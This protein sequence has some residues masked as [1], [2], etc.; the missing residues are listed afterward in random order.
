MTPHT[1]PALPSQRLTRILGSLAPNPSTSAPQ[2]AMMR[3][4]APAAE[5]D[6]PRT[7][8]DALWILTRATAIAVLMLTALAPVS[9]QTRVQMIVASSSAA[10]LTPGDVVDGAQ[11]LSLGAAERVTL[12]D[13][14]GALRAIDGPFRGRPSDRRPSVEGG[15]GG[16]LAILADVLRL[17][18]DPNT[19]KLPGPWLA[20][21]QRTGHVCAQA[22]RLVFWRPA[23]ADDVRLSIE[24]GARKANA[25]WPKGAETIALPAALFTN[26][27]SYPTQV[28]SEPP[29]VL[30]VHIAST[31]P[32]SP[33]DLAVWMAT[34]GCK[35]QALTLL[36]QIR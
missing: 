9:A 32:A 6:M 34:R 5:A 22:D 36:D 15:D 28:G 18:R 27:A 16:K 8:L 2:S 30:T 10:A 1:A 35:T 14:R 17:M 33:V 13:D 3:P 19:V 25:A 26:G 12:I 31:V 4:V 7:V 11:T 21:T 29:V 24:I 20:S 23:T